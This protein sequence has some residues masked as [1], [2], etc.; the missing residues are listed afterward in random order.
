[1]SDGARGQSYGFGNVGE[2]LVSVLESVRL[3]LLASGEEWRWLSQSDLILEGAFSRVKV[4]EAESAGL[5]LAAGLMN[6]RRLREEREPLLPVAATG[7]VLLDGRVAAIRGLNAK[8]EEAKQK[9]R[10]LK[11]IFTPLNC[12]SVQDLD[13]QIQRLMA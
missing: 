11:G 4:G 7:H 8:I 9:I 3:T 2:S 10:F 13:L 5:A 12:S 6:L 1:M